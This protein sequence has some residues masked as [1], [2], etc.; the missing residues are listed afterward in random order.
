MISLDQEQRLALAKA[1]RCQCMSCGVLAPFAEAVVVAQQNQVMAS[2]CLACFAPGRG[3]AVHRTSDGIVVRALGEDAPAS[4]IVVPETA[5]PLF[6]TI[7]A[8]R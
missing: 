7:Q 5:V 8:K 4:Q 2:F 1:G 6:G 3:F